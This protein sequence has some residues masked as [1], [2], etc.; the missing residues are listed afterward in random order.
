MELLAAAQDGGKRARQQ[1]GGGLDEL[2]DQVQTTNV[3]WDVV[4][5]EYSDLIQACDE[6]LLEQIDYSILPNADA[7]FVEGA[8]GDCGVGT[9]VWATVYAYDKNAFPDA[10]PTKVAD[11]F[12]LKNFP[13]KR[14]LR[15]DPR[16]TLE[17][18]LMASGV[19]AS[20]VY[21]TLA[22]PQGV[23]RALEELDKIRDSIVWWSAGPEPAR[24]L[25]LSSM[26]GCRHS[27]ISGSVSRVLVICV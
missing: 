9:Y 5:M 18:A 11:F 4:D 22:T 19:P 17:W 10:A 26:T 27:R 14:G 7:D 16:G 6:G 13:G 1:R 24:M 20:E 12:D 25:K 15:E 3:L 23:D 8:L 21:D 2:R